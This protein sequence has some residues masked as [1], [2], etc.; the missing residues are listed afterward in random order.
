MSGN[1]VQRWEDIIPC[2]RGPSYAHLALGFHPS[3]PTA[4]LTGAIISCAEILDWDGDGG[5]DILVSSWDACYGGVV[6]IFPE[7]KTDDDGIFCVGAG[8]V[9]DGVSGIASVL[10]QGGNFGLLTASRLRT[11]LWLFPNIGPR[12]APRFGEPI[13][14]PLEAD[15]LHDGELL[16]RAVFVDI[17][18]DGKQELVVGTDFWGDYWPD[19]LEWF[20]QGY[21]PYTAQG[22]WRGGPLRGHLYVFRNSGT[23]MRPILERGQPLLVNGQPVE[24]YGQVAP[25]FAD[26]SG[27][28]HL[29]MVCGDF[30]DRLQFFP[31]LGGGKFGAGQPLRAAGGGELILDH[32]I[33]FPTAVDGD[34]QGHIDLIVTAEDGCV[35]YLRNTGKMIDN[36][37]AFGAPVQ[38]PCAAER[39]RAG[40]EAVP[41]AADWTG[42]GL[43][44]LVVGNSTGEI[45]F[46]P[47][48]GQPEAPT[49][50]REWRLCAGGEPISMRAGHPG[51]IQGPA[52][53]K[54]GYI[55]PTAADW[56][57]DGQP[58][59]LTI[60]ADGRHLFFRCVGMGNPPEFA[61]PLALTFEGNPLRTNWR[62]R[63]AVVDWCADGTLSYLCLDED[64]CLADY[65]RVSDTVLEDKRRMVFDDGS[66]VRFTEDFGGGLGRIRLCV[67]DWSGNGR[68]DILVGTHARAS[69]PPGPGGMP[70]HTTAQAAVLL[71]ENVGG[72]DAPRFAPPRAILYQGEPIQIGMHSCS[73]EVVD[74]R[75]RGQ[76][77]LLVGAEEG[78][79]L[80]FKREGLSW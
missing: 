26:F 47:N 18:G 19:G 25:T 3:V 9:V 57:G 22:E 40:V 66:P 28:G 62:V 43:A 61:A 69:V 12:S 60:T 34:G 24:L 75:G 56:D 70:R 58:D 72:N 55:C 76:L 41:V 79:L 39:I 35:S 44:D 4:N 31:A 74:W 38:I 65:R 15:W 29:D 37:P 14:I 78:S 73:P 36:V 42:N 30:L 6:Q 17:D 46:F 21:T 63:P 71:L 27:T 68:Y 13:E 48:L 20:E 49:F 5:R 23:P 7:A 32:C 53:V 54:F 10:A 64:G 77:D 51:T 80:W 2:W 1:S 52:E 50:G 67:C 33:H 8:R 45:L 16:H 59:L 11:N